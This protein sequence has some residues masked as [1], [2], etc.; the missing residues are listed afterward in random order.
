MKTIIIICEGDTEVE[1]CKTNLNE[2]LGYEKYIIM[3]KN[4]KG[5][6]NWQRI[7]Y[8]IEKSLKSQPDV[9]VTT[10]ID[11]YG[12]KGTTFPQWQESQNIMD[13]RERIDF[14]ENEMHK[15]IENSLQNRFIPYLQLHEFEALLFNNIEVF[16]EN[17]E[18]AEYDKAELQ[19][20]FS[21]FPD[22]EM[23]ND[24]KE[25]SPS[26]RLKDIISIYDKAYL[27]N[28]IIKS[29]GLA[30]IYNKN[31]HFREWIDKLR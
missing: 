16:E 5:N 6:C 8:F 24:R 4:I 26:H 3:P 12:L 10:M 23:I 7:K 25:T 15:D 27:G 14:L 1:F 9:V 31:Q 29:I 2:Y 19:K 18:D 17:F 30:N 21:E 28:L 20:I 22:P 11:Y 13:K